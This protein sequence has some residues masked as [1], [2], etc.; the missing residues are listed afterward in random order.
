MF[1]GAGMMEAARGAGVT[2]L[3]D[4]RL[5]SLLALTAVTIPAPLLLA[6]GEVRFFDDF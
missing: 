3:G 6:P 4:E 2:L 1:P 5:A